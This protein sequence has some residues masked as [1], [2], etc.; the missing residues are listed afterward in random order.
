MAATDRKGETRKILCWLFAVVSVLAAVCL[1]LPALIFAIS[2]Q[3]HP[4]PL[5]VSFWLAVVGASSG[6]AGVYFGRNLHPSR[7]LCALATA[8]CALP[9]AAAV[10]HGLAARLFR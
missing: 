8:V 10:V 3:V 5:R 1:L 2:A 4:I 7:V 6:G 9:A